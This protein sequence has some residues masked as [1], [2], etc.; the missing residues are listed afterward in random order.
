MF[1]SCATVL[2]HG[3]VPPRSVLPRAQD[4]ATYLRK[5]IGAAE[6]ALKASTKATKATLEASKASFDGDIPVLKCWQDMLT[7]IDTYNQKQSDV[8]SKALGELKDQ[9]KELEQT[10][11]T[12]RPP[13]ARSC[14]PTHTAS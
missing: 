1:S 10:R 5:E 12:V 6:D 14:C 9:S 13:R 2:C 8:I 7:S 4:A 11:K 3:P